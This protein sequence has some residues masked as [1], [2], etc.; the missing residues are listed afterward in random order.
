MSGLLTLMLRGAPAPASAE[1]LASDARL[2]PGFKPI[3]DRDILPHLVAF[4]EQ[5]VRALRSLRWR[6]F[7]AIPVTLALVAATI[8]A[9]TQIEGKKDGF[10]ELLGMAVMG[11]FAW[12][13]MQVKRYKGDIKSKV[14]PSVF[15]YFGES[16]TYAPKAE[17]DMKIWESTGIIPRYTTK[18]TEDHVQ[19][20]YR[21]VRLDIIEA[22]LVRGSG[23][24]RTTVFNGLLAMVAVGKRFQGTTLVHH[25]KGALGNWFLKK[26]DS[27][28]QVVR[29]EDPVFEQRFEVRSTDQV[30]ARYLLTTSFMERLMALETALGSRIQAC[31]HQN[32]LLLLIPSDRLWFEPGPVYQPATFVED[33]A[34]IFQQMRLLFQIID[35]LKLD[36]TT[37]L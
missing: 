8:F 36:D 5:R 28:L 24:R 32:H 23:K 30:E 35:V 26:K 18:K 7:L 4:E 34:L 25:D 20:M 21:D 14:F 6:M 3:Y 37:R 9:F 27:N 17:M 33:I 22:N 12:A 16:F 29:L 31:F 13:Y 2:E 1:I 11:V 15:R 19:G 10:G